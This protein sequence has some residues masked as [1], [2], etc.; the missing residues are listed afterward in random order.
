MNF[1]TNRQTDRRTDKQTRVCL[2]VRLSVQNVQEGLRRRR[3]RPRIHNSES[4]RQ[5]SRRERESLQER[6]T[7][8]QAQAERQRRTR[9]REGREE[10][11]ARQQADVER[12]RRTREREGSEARAARQQADVER[13]RRVRE[14]EGSEE[15]AARQQADVERRRRTREREGSE[16]RAARQQADAERRRRTRARE[17][18]EERA[19]RQQA[20]AER[21]RRTRAR[22]GREERAA[23]QQADV[24]RRRRTRER[25]GSEERAARQQADAERRRRTRA[26]EGREERAAR[27]QADVERRRRLREREDSEERAARQQADVERQRRRRVRESSGERRSGLQFDAERHQRARMEETFQERDVRLTSDA[28]R[29]RRLRNR[30]PASLGIALRSRLSEPGYLGGLNY[31]CENCGA[32]HFLCE[33]K[34]QHPGRFFDCCELGRFNLDFFSNFPEGLRKLYV[35]EPTDSVEQNRVRRNFME[36]IRTFNSALAMASMGAQV[37]TIRGRGPYCYR[38]HGQVYHRIGPLHPLEGE[39]RQYGQIYILDTEMAAQERLG[40]I[41]NVDCNPALMRFLSELISNVN[42]YAQSYK[43]M[44]EVEQ[45][46][47]ALAQLENRSPGNIMM[48]FEESRERGLARRQYDIPTA[49][50]VSVVYVGEDNDV[51]PTRSLAVHLRR[52]TGEQLMNIRDIDKICDPL[53]YPL[54]FPTGTGGWDPTLSNNIGGRVTQ[55]SYYSY[56][57]S[58]RDSFNPILHAGKLFQQFVVDAYVKIEQNRLNFQRRNQMV[59][60]A[61]SYRGLQDYLAGEDSVTGPPGRRI[62]LPSTHIGSPRSMQQSFQDAMA[63]VARFGKPTYFITMTCNP[64]WKE[65]QENLFSGQTPSDRPDLVSRVFNA[66]MRELRSDLFKKHVLGEVQAYVYV[67]EFQ[68][69]GLPH[70]HMLLIMKEGWKVRT[71]EECDKAV[72]AEVPNPRTEP[73]LHSA[74]TSYMIHRKCGLADPHSPCMQGGSCS[75]KFPKTL[76]QETSIEGDGY[77]L[78]RRRSLHP[79]EIHGTIYSDEWVVPT[80]PYLILKYDC[81]L[82]MEICGM[83]SAVKYLYKY[84]FK[85]PDRANVNIESTSEHDEIKQHLNTRYVCAPQSVYRIFGYPVQD[86]SHTVCRL[87]VHLPD[88]QTVYFAEGTER[89]SVSRA[90]ESL[91]TLTAYFQLNARCAEIFHGTTR[92]ESSVDARNLHYFQI[93]E[94]FTFHRNQGWTPRKGGGKQIGRMYTVSPRDTE[95][96]SLRI[97]LLNTKG[98]TSFEDIRTVDGILYATFVDAAKAA[99]FLDDDS[100]LR[101]SLQEAVQYQSAATI[102][103]FF[104]CL[105]CFCDVLQAQD[106]WDEFADAMSDDYIHQGME[107]ELAVSFAY[108]DILDKMNLLGKDLTQFV[109]PPTRERPSLPRTFIDYEAYERE[110]N[111]QYET[112]NAMQRAAAD[113]IL[114]A[115]EGNGN[116]C[117]FVDGPGGSGK[118]Y[119]YNTLYNIAL[120]RRRH[121]ICVAWTG[122]AANLLPRGKTVS[123][124]FKLNIADENR[125]SLMKRQEREAQQ[126]MSTDMIIWDEISMAP[127]V[128]LEAVDSLLRDIMQIDVPFGGKVMVLGGDFRQVL[129]VVEHGQREDIVGACILKSSLWPLFSI[130]HLNLNMRA[131]AGGNAWQARLLEIGNSDANDSDSRVS[132]P[133]T[134]LCVTDI[135]TEI[136]GSSIDPSGTSQLCEYAIIAPKNI[137]VHHLNEDALNRLHVDNPEDE[138]WYRSVD[139]AIYPE[140]QNDQLYPVEYLNSL[141][142][143]GM[144]PHNLHL[145]KGTIVML[146]RNLDVANGL[147]NGTRLKIETLGRFTLGCR[148]FSGERNGQ[149]AIIPRIDNYW[150]NRTPFRLRRR[151]FPV[152]VAFAMTINKAQGQSFSRIG[153]YLPEDVFAH[154]QL[155]VALSRARTPEGIKIASPSSS[156]KNIVYTEVLL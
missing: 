82:N 21:R 124:T 134:M 88:F 83:I 30:P 34:P 60:R 96:Y 141:T 90:Q 10:R 111:F 155:Y 143:T 120:G 98:K 153:I 15:R 89:E 76:R 101:Q 64:Q 67:V 23:R 147:C 123:S 91:T 84:I 126:L 108:Y 87:A 16:E 139:E 107:R 112:L 20:D 135:V 109:T 65:I 8:Q 63:I 53:T 145:K 105:I 131:Q 75:K 115:L 156:L 66:K 27:Q 33:V 31:I 44:G 61:D 51:P 55:K 116:K 97:L 154:G 73:E 52:P 100:Y 39:R 122:I 92:P 37:D 79:F 5:R 17:G 103:S 140:G 35:Q 9:E 150:D 118:T 151:Q 12:Q 69:R 13:R 77:P 7:R 137:H 113:N 133:N 94:H 119:L 42:V 6:T 146:L 148:F 14:R 59:L 45:A 56:L 2:S 47:F 106:L 129:P 54:L 130:Y 62:I 86:K 95:R 114:S 72:C 24:E 3:G 38:I 11:A 68:K 43:M 74:I 32:R 28:E 93:P 58:I 50:E 152:R 104:A 18:R 132:V 81:H 99:G 125:T 127:K 78:Y 138:K 144:P 29:H 25:E 136:F 36:N 70:C 48:V 46:E 71:S 128:A 40:N 149:L 22:E 121:V 142:P 110:G 49:N 57:I 19:A 41:R 80:N 85:G 117:I 4:E 26:R 1:R 102:R